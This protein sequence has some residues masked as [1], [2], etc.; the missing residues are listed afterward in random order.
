M[1]GLV[2]IQ[3]ALRSMMTAHAREREGEKGATSTLP[4]LSLSISRQS[5]SDHGVE[6]HRAGMLTRLQPCVQC[7]FRTSLSPSVVYSVPEQCGH[8][9]R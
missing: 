2:F 3:P 7:I 1:E 8:N 4:P 5:R 9:E 6:Y